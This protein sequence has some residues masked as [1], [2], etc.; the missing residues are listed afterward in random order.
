MRSD[1]KIP[2]NKVIEVKLESE[3]DDKLALLISQKH[4]IENMAKC[5]LSFLI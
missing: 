1:N 2:S 5:K 3:N 4:I